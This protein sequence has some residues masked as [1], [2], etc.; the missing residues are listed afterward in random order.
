MTIPADSFT[1]VGAT[2][3]P[4]GEFRPV[5]GGNFDFRKPVPIGQRIRDGRDQQLVYGRG[6]DHNWVIARAPSKDLRLNARVEDKETGRVMEVLSTQPGI[7]FYS[8]NFL[9]GTIVGKSGRVY[10]QGD[11]LCLEPQL[12]PDTPN[13]PAFGSARLDPGQ[14]YVN[15]MAYRFSVAR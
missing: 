4:T 1:P 2:L 8:G 7:Q 14:T 13:Q 15:R 12:F 11:A 3:I 9:D 6:Y 10:R 5:A